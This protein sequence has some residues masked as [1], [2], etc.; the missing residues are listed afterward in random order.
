M[1]LENTCMGFPGEASEEQYWVEIEG[2]GRMLPYGMYK[3][4]NRRDIDVVHKRF[5]PDDNVRCWVLVRN[6][7]H[8]AWV[9]KKY[10]DEY[11]YPLWPEERVS[12]AE[13]DAIT[14]KHR[15]IDD[16]ASVTHDEIS[17]VADMD[18]PDVLQH[19][20]T[21]RYYVAKADSAVPDDE[22]D[23]LRERLHDL[24][25]HVDT[26]HVPTVKRILDD[27]RNSDA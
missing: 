3:T 15:A 24:T 19:V 8:E 9:I 13:L 5:S 2:D 6:G 14:I 20:I 21:A 4:V 12:E 27:H 17:A 22:L 25:G 26:R 10:R 23:H 11:G 1:R 18:D 16:G 7:A